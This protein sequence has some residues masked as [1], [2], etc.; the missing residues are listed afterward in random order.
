[1]TSAVPFACSCCSHTCSITIRDSTS[2]LQVQTRRLSAFPHTPNLVR[3]GGLLCGGLPV[4]CL[5][6]LRPAVTIMHLPTHNVTLKPQILHDHKRVT[7]AGVTFEKCEIKG[8]AAVR[9]V[10]LS[11]QHPP[12]LPAGPEQ[13]LYIQ[14]HLAVAHPS[15]SA[16]PLSMQT[17]VVSKG[18]APK[19]GASHSR[20][21]MGP[22]LQRIGRPQVIASKVGQDFLLGVCAAA[23]HSESS[24]LHRPQQRS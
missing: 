15:F 18:Q 10:P 2:S 22:K 12:R 21:M 7:V 14:Q 16:R 19:L 13:A 24:F 8:Q 9:S 11:I 6:L 20:R 5:G 3:S 23:A 1:M 17:N 4:A